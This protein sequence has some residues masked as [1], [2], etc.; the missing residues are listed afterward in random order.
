MRRPGS[1]PLAKRS[2][3][4]WLL[5]VEWLDS[6]RASPTSKIL[7]AGPTTVRHNYPLQPSSAGVMEAITFEP[8]SALRAG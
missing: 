3:G 1:A 5:T 6:S 2:T 7:R 8:L 4:G